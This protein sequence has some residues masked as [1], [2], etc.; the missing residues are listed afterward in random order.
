MSSNSMILYH[1]TDI[2]ALASMCTDN[3][4]CFRMTNA[5]FLNDKDEYL[6]GYE[7]IQNVYPE[8]LRH[9]RDKTGESENHYVVSLSDTF[10]SL[11]MW[12]TYGKKGNGV[13]IGLDKVKLCEWLEE[14]GFPYGLCKYNEELFKT[15][16]KEESTP[17]YLIEKAK[18]SYDNFGDYV[19]ISWSSFKC[20]LYKNPAFEYEK[21]FRFSEFVYPQT[22]GY[23][24]IPNIKFRERNNLLI[25]YIE[26][27]IPYRL[28]SSI[29]LGPSNGN[30]LNMLSLDI[31]RKRYRIRCNIKQSELPYR[32]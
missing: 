27:V 13:A 11:P 21:E 1:Y 26:E 30:D 22:S 18:E 12:N 4:F 29:L 5:R 17:R 6:A 19:G 15:R 24:N 8:V 23:E 2:E 16:F 14:K 25:P 28:I 20:L 31:L 3:G 9:V 7:I 10:D 32:S